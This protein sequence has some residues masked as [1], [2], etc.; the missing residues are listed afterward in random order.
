[1]YYNTVK[2]KSDEL[3]KNKT[4]A[5]SQDKQIWGLLA[6]TRKAYTPFEIQAH[7]YFKDNNWPITSIRRALNTIVNKNVGIEKLK[8]V[9]KGKYGRMNHKWKY[10]G[11]TSKG[12]ER[13]SK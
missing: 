8:D 6:F 1:M 4:K 11:K 13:F 7:P 3:K 9:S 12:L 10:T 5:Q 2:E